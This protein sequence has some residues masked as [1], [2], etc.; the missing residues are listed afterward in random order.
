VTAIAPHVFDPNTDPRISALCAE[1]GAYAPAPQ[2]RPHHPAPAGERVETY[3][4][5]CAH[6]INV[7]RGGV[8][9]AAGHVV[10]VVQITVHTFNATRARPFTATPAPYLGGRLQ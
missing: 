4:E 3:C 8:C 6:P 9:I 5:T 10:S 7:R 2:H 1:C